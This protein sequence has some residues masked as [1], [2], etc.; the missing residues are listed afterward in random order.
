MAL[1][2]SLTQ[3]FRQGQ[4]VVGGGYRAYF[5]P[6]NATL[7][8]SQTST[9][10]GPVILDL[11]VQGPFNENNPPSGYYD[12]GWIDGFKV[13]PASKIGVIRS[14]Y[15]GAV[16]AIY[17]G[18]VGETFDFMFKEMS[19]MALKIA[20]GAEIFNLLSNPAA[21][22][23]SVGPLVSSGAVAVPVGISG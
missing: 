19:R 22:A 9:T 23:S 1:P 13:T 14:G 4:L 16:R 3:P 15:R 11:Q 18:E 21:V 6:F 12:L 5:A 7:G 20:S 17:R 2:K 10:L 8:H